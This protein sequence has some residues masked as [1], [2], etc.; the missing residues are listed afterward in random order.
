[1]EGKHEQSEASNKIILRI[2]FKNARK[3]CTNKN[4]YRIYKIHF[5]GA[6]KM[7]TKDKRQTY[8]LSFITKQS[9][10]LGQILPVMCKPVVPGD[11]ISIAPNFNIKLGTLADNIR[12][13]FQISIKYVYVRME[14][15]WTDFQ[16]YYLEKS[17]FSGAEPYR[18]FSNLD[19][20]TYLTWVF[21]TNIRNYASGAIAINALPFRA[22]Y[23]AYLEHYLKMETS[24]TLTDTQLSLASGQDSTTPLTIQYDYYRHDLY[25]RLRVSNVF[26]PTLTVPSPSLEITWQQIKDLKAATNWEEQLREIMLTGK[27]YISKMFGV[28]PDP[29][30]TT[31]LL[32]EF[33]SF[34]NIADVVSTSAT[35]DAP[36]GATVS[37]AYAS[38][39]LKPMVFN[40]P[41]H[42]YVLGLISIV[43]DA[44]F[45]DG[46]QPEYLHK[47]SPKEYY[48]PAYVGL[49]YVPAKE[50]EVLAT[51]GSSDANVIGYRPIYDELRT[52]IDFIAGDFVRTNDEAILRRDAT[53]ISSLAPADIAKV[54]SGEFDYI[55]QDNDLPQVEI[56]GSTSLIWNRP[57]PKTLDNPLTDM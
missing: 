26:T 35:T 7:A 5:K 34:M 1:L 3:Q 15:I 4:Y 47:T 45:I 25:T 40:V 38:N 36:L 56:T 9:G 32:G 29:A 16:N 52:P 46:I 48:N 10:K 14:Q 51:G 12:G 17:G 31:K 24:P 39:A 57:I 41:A 21:P 53:S 37:M 43:P 50:I 30:E 20:N 18:S 33:Y 23:R 54:N 8:D 27:N 11:I 28:P 6:L 22:Y 13:I 55:F 2:C 44:K 49:G 19:D 42:G